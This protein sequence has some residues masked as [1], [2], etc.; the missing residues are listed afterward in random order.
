[1]ISLSTKFHYIA[2]CG[3]SLV[4]FLDQHLA[5]MMEL[6]RLFTIP[7]WSNFSLHF[8]SWLKSDLKVDLP[9]NI[10]ETVLE[11]YTFCIVIHCLGFSPHKH[12]KGSWLFQLYL[13]LI[14][15]SQSWNATLRKIQRMRCL[16]FSEPK[17]KLLEK[18]NMLQNTQAL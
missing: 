17:L 18:A 13:I 2:L 8:Y 3:Y 7:L 6:Q 4:I 1:M 11:M 5:I 9:L 10:R 16:W 12:S 14:F 15:R